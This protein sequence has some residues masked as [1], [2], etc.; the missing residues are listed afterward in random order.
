MCIRDSNITGWSPHKIC[1]AGIARTF[2]TPRIFADLTIEKNVKLAEKFGRQH[3]SKTLDM[4]PLDF[5]G[6]THKANTLARE[7]S[8]FERRLLEIAMALA[9]HPDVILL[10]EPLSGLSPE[11]L[12]VG[13]ELIAR[14]RAELKVT[15]FWIEHIMEAILNNVDKI[16]VLNAGEKISEGVPTQ[17]VSDKKVIEAYL[18][19]AE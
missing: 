15:V 6:L 4:K 13:I 18:G 17:I 16:I 14:I 2:Q 10:D 9:T 8:L 19:E 7:T 1:G 11:E 5:V 3:K 12:K